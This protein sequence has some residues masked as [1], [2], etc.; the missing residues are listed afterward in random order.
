MRF[1][2]R[3]LEIHRKKVDITE[4]MTENEQTNFI[5]FLK[6][7]NNFMIYFSRLIK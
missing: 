6:T 3:L 2:K 5:I 4:L 7:K 1:F